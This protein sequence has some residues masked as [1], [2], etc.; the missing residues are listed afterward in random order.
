MCDRR[1][2]SLAGTEGATM[3]A[4]RWFVAFAACAAP[5]LL[6]TACT[7]VGVVPEVPEEA[8]GAAALDG[9]QA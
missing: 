8:A 4:K 5:A 6:G 9:V 1:R 3:S 7:D 2:L